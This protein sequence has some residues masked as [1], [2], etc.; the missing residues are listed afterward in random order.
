[1]TMKDNKHANEETTRRPRKATQTGGG[2]V[3]F[4]VS[5]KGD[6]C[7]GRARGQK[8]LRCAAALLTSTASCKNRRSFADKSGKLR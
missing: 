8:L 5:P 4:C 2:P 7:A 3:A 6:A 1:M